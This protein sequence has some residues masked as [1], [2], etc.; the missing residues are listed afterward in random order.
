MVAG[1]MTGGSMSEL[2]FSGTKFAI[3]ATP[4]VTTLIMS[5]EA[6]S[7][8]LNERMHDPSA[9]TDPEYRAWAVVDATVDGIIEGV[10]EYASLE[11]VIQAPLNA[12]WYTKVGIAALV[13]GS[14]EG[15]SW[16][17]GQAYAWV[18]QNEDSI[19]AQAQTYCD[20][21]G[22]TDEAER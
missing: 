6:A 5:S 9:W 18:R 14:E 8:K 2:A 20:Q 21:Y 11:M 17:L 16:V 19:Q 1:G 7:N 4:L 13:E 10:T 12:K 22:I 3:E 15:A